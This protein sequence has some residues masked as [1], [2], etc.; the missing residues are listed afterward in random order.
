MLSLHS[1]IMHQEGDFSVKK[2]SE[3]DSQKPGHDTP[4]STPRWVKVFGVIGLLLVLLFVV[5]HLTG[6]SPFMHMSHMN[7]VQS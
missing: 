7:G 5:L 1:E 3:T 4:P 2:L 6:H